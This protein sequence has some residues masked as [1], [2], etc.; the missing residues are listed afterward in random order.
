MYLKF[1]VLILPAFLF[2]DFLYSSVTFNAYCE[3]YR[4]DP[5]GFEPEISKT[6]KVLY[7]LSGKTNCKEAFTFLKKLK[8]LDLSHKN[9]TTLIPLEGLTNLIT[10]DI[11][12][13]ELQDLW[14]LE[15]EKQIEVLIAHH[16]EIKNIVPLSQLKELMI[17]DLSHNNLKFAS[18][19]KG[20]TNILKYFVNENPISKNEEEMDYLDSMLFFRKLQ[21]RGVDYQFEESDS[22]EE[23][24]I[25]IVMAAERGDLV[26]FKKILSNPVIAAQLTSGEFL[27]GA[28]NRVKKMILAVRESYSL[29]YDLIEEYVRIKRFKPFVRSSLQPF[30]H[31]RMMQLNLLFEHHFAEGKDFPFSRGDVKNLRAFLIR[32]MIKDPKVTPQAILHHMDLW[33]ESIKKSGIPPSLKSGFLMP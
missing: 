17:L 13:N 30:M 4:K 26:F 24:L 20:L 8:Y 23:L 2:S 5:Q 12:H 6:V 29:A 3:A 28:P 21:K 32:K 31:K 11:S 25:Q 33:L 9:L 10:L 14:G 7:D 1:L 18:P 27:L 16:N 22:P 19:L 15:N